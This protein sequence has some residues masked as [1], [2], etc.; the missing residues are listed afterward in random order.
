MVKTFFL[1]IKYNIN[2]LKIKIKIFDLSFIL[3]VK[4]NLKQPQ[5]IAAYF[6]N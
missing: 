4:L 2:N 5:K 3:I 6:L 1:H